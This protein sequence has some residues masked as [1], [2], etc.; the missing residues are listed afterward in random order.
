M[1]K[2]IEIPQGQRDVIKKALELYIDEFTGKRGTF[3]GWTEFESYELFDA[4]QLKAMMDYPIL[5]EIS[6]D[7]IS[8]F[9]GKYG[10]D[11]PAY[12][13][14]L[15]KKNVTAEKKLTTKSALIRHMLDNGNDFTYT[16]MIKFCFNH[17]YPNEKY[18]WREN[19]GHYSCAFANKGYW[20][21]A[22]NKPGS[23]KS[24]RNYVE[25]RSN[26]SNVGGRS[27][28]ASG[29]GY[30]FKGEEFVYKNENGRWSAF[31]SKYNPNASNK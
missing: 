27:L 9:T 11:F 10:V 25:S 15:R 14:P 29:V 26:E 6:E 30:M 2:Q 18:D 24:F 17:K 4:N 5:I 12:T 23:Y 20:T 19:R 13:I 1:S 28:L 22:A 31:S 21:S 16:E 8:E 3:R 7:E